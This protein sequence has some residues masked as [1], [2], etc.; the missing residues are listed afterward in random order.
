[1]NLNSLLTFCGALTFAGLGGYLAVPVLASYIWPYNEPGVNQLTVPH[2][3]PKIALGYAGAV[4]G[5]GFYYQICC[6]S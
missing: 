1:M 3:F 5:A 2:L 4:A 6:R